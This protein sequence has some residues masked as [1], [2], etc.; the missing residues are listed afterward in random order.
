[1]TEE[2]IFRA[3]AP[4]VVEVTGR[5]LEE[6][7]PSSVLVE[8]LGAESIDLVDLSF[9]IEERFGV[10]IEPNE[11][12]KRVRGRIPDGAY[13]RDGLL[14]G[15]AL[16]A[17]REEIPEIDPGRLRDGL[18]KADL[19]SLLTVEVFARLIAGKLASRPA[20]PAEAAA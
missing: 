15:E 20:G 1:M 10:A 19:P 5:K 3:L 8:E 2:E 12:E 6:V 17:L 16:A 13:E 14:T 11:F 4:L 9:L 7:R 18:R